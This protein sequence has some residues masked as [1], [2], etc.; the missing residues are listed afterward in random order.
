[1]SQ[2]GHIKTYQIGGITVQ[3]DSEIDEGNVM[4]TKVLVSDGVLCWVA[5]ENRETFIKK[6]QA[7]VE[8]YCI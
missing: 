3:T 1:M 2:T 8:E 7:L 4:D 5:G 6:L